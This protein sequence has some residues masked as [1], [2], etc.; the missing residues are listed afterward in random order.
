MRSIK[1]QIPED[2]NVRLKVFNLV[3]REVVT[4]VKQRLQAGTY[5]VNFYTK[6]LT[7]G[8]YFYRLQIEKYVETKKI[9]LIK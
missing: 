1:F 6:N 7:S 3:G 5:T 4:L 8:V 2:G 9:I